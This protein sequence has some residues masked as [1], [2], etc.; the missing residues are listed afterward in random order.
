MVSFGQA[1]M[2]SR[3][4]EDQKQLFMAAYDAHNKLMDDAM[5][6]RGIDRHLYGLRKAAEVV[7][8]DIK[9]QPILFTDEAFRISGGD[10]NF[11]LSTSFIGYMGENDELGS[12]GY[13][14]A[15]C[16]DGYG[17][18]YRIGKNRLQVTI[19]DWTGSKSELDS[20]GDNIVWSLTKMASLFTYK[21]NL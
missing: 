17:A 12:Y 5:N 16:P 4:T 21:A 9:S 13:V 3:S 1:V 10:G 19:T 8:K 18:F 7:K 11:L 15:M 20:Y 2:G 14:T 6:G